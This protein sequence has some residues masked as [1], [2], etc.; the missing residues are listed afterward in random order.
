MKKSL[1]A[2]L[3]LLILVP[4]SAAENQAEQYLTLPKVFNN[5]M[6]LQ[7]NKDVRIW[8]TAKPNTVVDI[9]FNNQSI[10]AQVNNDGGWQLMLAPMLAGGPYEMKITSA[11]ESITYSDVLIG[12]VFLA[13]GQSNMAF[14]VALMNDDDVAQLRKEASKSQNVRYHE[15]A[16]IVSGGKRLNREDIPWM[17]CD[18]SKIDDWSAV[19][20]YFAIKLSKNQNVPVGIIGCNHGDSPVEAWISPKAFEDSPDLINACLLQAK[21][22]DVRQFY[23]NASSLHT[24]MLQKVLGYS[25]NGVI[26]YQGEANGRK[27]DTYEKL[28]STLISDWRIQWNEPKLPF[29]FAQLAS[30][31]VSNEPTNI[32]WAKLRDAQLNVWQKTPNTSMITTIDV[33]TLNDIH[34]KNKKPVGERFV[35]AVEHLV[36]GSNNEYAGP[37]FTSMKKSGNALYIS[38]SHADGLHGKDGDEIFE[39][40]ICGSD[41]NYKPAKASI[42]QN[43]VK[44]WS[45]DVENPTGVRYAWKNNPEH[46]NLYNKAGFPAIPFCKDLEYK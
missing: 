38:F 29:V 45:N 8:G 12:D 15:V 44:V 5:H 1:L 4:Y 21:D 7:R 19:A 6:V 25:I 11:G 2:Y 23:R 17:V 10:Q 18:D 43:K 28:F 20:T 30:Y 34:P 40:E 41:N 36:Y 32:T 13:S 46:P 35:A 31:T 3:F 9:N 42:E 24:L 39:F 26:W 33:G 22:P 14:K 16:R 37:L 27:P